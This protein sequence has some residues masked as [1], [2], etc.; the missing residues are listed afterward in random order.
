MCE[1][2]LFMFTAEFFK[3]NWSDVSK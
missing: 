3:P 2:M 1:C